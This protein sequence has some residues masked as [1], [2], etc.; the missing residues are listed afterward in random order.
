[1]KEFI[2]KFTDREI[3]DFS[4]VLKVDNEFFLV[5][6]ELMQAQEKIKKKISYIGIYIGTAEKPGLFLLQ[7]LAGHA[8][9]KVW[10]DEKGE[11]LFICKRDLFG[12][13]ISKSEGLIEKGDWVMVMNRH[14][15]CLGYGKVA[16]DLP[17]D[18]SD[19]IAV[20]RIFDIGDFLRRERKK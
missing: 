5:T 14:D 9:R 10:V 15:E 17:L 16:A 1:M 4:K 11:W 13:S 2:E 20:R 3:I 18:D 19:K 12:S 6:S 7:K 8:K